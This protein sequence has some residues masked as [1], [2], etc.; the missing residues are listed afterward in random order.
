VKFGKLLYISQCIKKTKHKVRLSLLSMRELSNSFR[1]N[2]RC[3]W[4]DARTVCSYAA[5]A[6]ANSVLIRLQSA[7]SVG[8]P[9][10]RKSSSLTEARN[11]STTHKLA[12]NKLLERKKK[13]T[14]TLSLSGSL[15]CLKKKKKCIY[16]PVKWL[17]VI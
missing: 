17:C 10:T 15:L 11:K 5:M 3:A 13:V 14:R 8:K 6:P 2:V 1:L 12:D 4:T 7:Q 16:S 9:W